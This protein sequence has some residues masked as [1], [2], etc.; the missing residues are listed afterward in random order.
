MATP[1]LTHYRP[2]DKSNRHNRLNLRFNDAEYARILRTAANSGKL[3][4]SWAADI[5][6]EAALKKN[7][8][9]G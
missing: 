3:P 4:S 7:N 6:V 5:L 2:R 9:D 8:Q 1:P